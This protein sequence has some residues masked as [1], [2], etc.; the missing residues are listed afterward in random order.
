LPDPASLAI[1]LDLVGGL[2][3]DMFVAAMVDALPGL[4]PRVIAEVARVTPPGVSGPVYAETSTGGLRARRFGLV[5]PDEPSRRY[6]NGTHGDRPRTAPAPRAHAGGTSYP[7]LRGK[8]TAAQLSE[9]TQEH[10]LALLH[11]LAEAEA[12][13]HGTAL[14]DVHFHELADWDSLLDLVAAGCIAAALEGAHWTASAPPLGSGYVQTDHGRLPVPA[15][16]TAALLTGYRWRDDGIGGERV[17]P[18]GAAILRHLVPADEYAA[19]QEAGRLLGVG[20]G[21]GTRQLPG[22]PNMVRALVFERGDAHAHGA[23]AVA[24]IE[25]DV[26]D[27]TGEELAVAGEALRS[28]ADVLDVSIGSRVGKKGRPLAAF[29]LL[30]RPQAAEDIAQRCFIET[31]TLGVRMREERRRVLRRDEVV[32]ATDA[33]ASARVKVAQRPGGVRTA[34]AADDDVVRAGGLDARRRAAAA[35]VRHV[36]GN[37]GT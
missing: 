1:H 19:R 4:G 8:L 18:T 6:T 34:K 28:A 27:M 9:G 32:S 7:S 13:V 33:G 23:D 25:F 35:A 24:V 31:S 20:C 12:Q 10:A 22:M 2:A 36:L 16:A 26:D 3:G 11:L 15:P 5:V 17:T 14:D 29:R 21:A 30:A 37:D